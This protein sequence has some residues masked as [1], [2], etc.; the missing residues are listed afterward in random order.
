MP[1]AALPRVLLALDVATTTGWA[2]GLLGDVRPRCGQWPLPRVHPHRLVLGAKV[3]ALENTLSR[4][5]EA[6]QVGLVVIAER[7]VGRSQAQI[8]TSFALDGAVE[9][10]CNR[11]GIA[12]R[13]HPEQTVRNEMHGR[14]PR[15]TDWKALALLWCEREGIAVSGHDAADAALLWRWTRDELVRQARVSMR[16]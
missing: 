14:H 3:T 8:R 16:V 12:M 7:F 2:V 11:A 15:G 13:V 1:D 10:E 6:E 5:I 4:F 9:S